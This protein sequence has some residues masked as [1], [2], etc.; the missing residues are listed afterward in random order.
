[1]TDDTNSLE[2]LA[3]LVRAEPTRP[4]VD[5]AEFQLTRAQ[6]HAGAIRLAGQLVERVPAG[7]PIGI[8]L[9]NEALYPV[10]ALACLAAGC[11]H[12]A[13]DPRYPA[14]RTELIA[15]RAGVRLILERFRAAD[16]VERF[17]RLPRL[18]LAPALVADAP[19]EPA[20]APR[21]L[22]ID[23]PFVLLFTSGTTGTPKGVAH[24]R[25]SLAGSRLRRIPGLEL[26]VEDRELA[27]WGPSTIAG[28]LTILGHVAYGSTLFLRD[29]RMGLGSLVGLLHDERITIFRSV[30]ALA[31]T[32]AGTDG[33]R[34]AL[35]NLRLF[36]LGGD[37]VFGSDLALLRPL[38]PPDCR[39]SVGFGSTEAGI[40]A[41]GYADDDSTGVVPLGFANPE[42][43]LEIL[44]P[45]GT[46]VAEGEVGELRSTGPA[47][48]IGFWHAGA[49]V[50]G[51]LP[52]AP[53]KP[54]AR[55][56]RTGDLFRQL[57]D[58]SFVHT[59]RVDR[60][61]KIAG[62]R[63]DLGDVEAALRTCAGVRDAAVVAIG[64]SSPR[65]V[66]FVV[67][68]DG[69][70]AE[71]VRTHLLATL[72]EHMVPG[73]IRVPSAIPYVPGFK[74]DLAAL[75]ELA[76]V[77]RTPLAGD[78]A[79]SRAV[80]PIADAVSHV[81]R[82]LLGAEAA[83]DR[84]GEAGGD[85]LA[86]LQLAYGIE[87]RLGRP[88]PIA[89]MSS[90]MRAADL[91]E[92]LAA[93]APPIAVPLVGAPTIVVLPGLLGNE[94]KLVDF[95][96]R[97]ARGATV[98]AATY[99]PWPAL[100]EHEATLGTI[101]DAV[102]EQIAAIAA[103]AP[104]VLVGYSFGGRIAHGV[105]GELER[106]GHPPRFVAILDSNDARDR[107]LEP[108]LS[109]NARLRRIATHA[110]TA[111]FRRAIAFRV[112]WRLAWVAVGTPALLPLVARCRDR[113]P[114][115]IDFAFE[116][117]ASLTRFLRSR[118]AMAAR[119]QPVSAPVTL[120][121]TAQTEPTVRDLGWSAATPNLT[122]EDALGV[123]EDMIVGAAGDDLARRILAAM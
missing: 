62:Q 30:P 38:L 14:A 35:A 72:P 85:S 22:G 109:A 103:E 89:S 110:R 45:D 29:A 7:T 76:A 33:A 20:A 112:G 84:F 23:D 87:R 69:A 68:R 47:T 79:P 70:T 21:P 60:M 17:A 53:G 46:P 65:L 94:P 96:R 49:L 16:T 67:V 80:G 105:A 36:Q 90:D 75:G 120:Y 114:L 81:W 91:I 71:A 78:V 107:P 122:I 31:R 101:V 83:D 40:I 58:G 2:M 64:E 32:L 11:P 88:I 121:R 57:P 43:L 34:P 95:Q 42:T 1:M 108:P 25:R 86:M 115:P 106:R 102:I 117:E 18:T 48:A 63:V 55:T 100:I 93:E 26:R 119:P 52:T 99:P 118:L 10:A 111:G 8:A 73:D 27:T 39:I 56:L 19:E 51:G 98:V 77:R 61:V 15:D 92:R 54:H 123:H 3:D 4:N 50:A 116:F 5:D 41:T 74:V 44:S 113:L 66:A 6:V 97:L 24:S 37:R 82:E 59:A 12:V 13:L 9:G 104:V 28:L